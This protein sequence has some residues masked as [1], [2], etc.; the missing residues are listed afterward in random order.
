[1]KTE[2]QAWREMLCRYLKDEFGKKMADTT[3]KNDDHLQ[4]LSIPVTNLEDVRR[5]MAILSK[6]R[7]T[8]IDTDMTLISIE[9]WRPQTLDCMSCY[10]VFFVF[11]F[12][13]TSNCLS[14]R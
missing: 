10:F 7:N 14:L 4:Q 1:M 3:V 9:V 11:Y 8:E 5:A 2:T 6:F 13:P 12:L